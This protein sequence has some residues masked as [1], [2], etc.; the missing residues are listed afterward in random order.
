MKIIHCADLHLGSRLTSLPSGDVRNSKKNE[1]LN[2]FTQ[3]LN[4]AKK[5]EIKII[6]L[7]GDVF[8]SNRPSK[9]DKNYFYDA[10]RANSD[11]TFLYLRGNH[12]TEES[13]NETLDNLITFTTDWKTYDFDNITISGIELSETNKTSLY[14]TIN[15]D[16]D[17]INI[18]MMHGDVSSKG[19]DF[20]DYKKLSNKNIDYLALGHIHS[21]MENRI[22]SRGVYVYPGCLVGRGFDELGEKG[23]VVLDVSDKVNYSFIPV[24]SHQFLE[25]EID[26]SGAKNLY[27]AK[28]II[29]DKIKDISKSSLL[30][31]IL[32][33]SVDFDITSID[34]SIESFFQQNFF[35]LKVY[36]NVKENINISD[37]LNDFSLK[38]EFVRKVYNDK[39]LSND[40][41]NEIL[42]LGMKLLNGEDIE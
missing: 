36:T 19:K 35:F 40:E 12:D 14:S 2:S 13:L 5:N 25:K 18:V 8:D 41:R 15:L 31:I 29:N 3:M 26:I 28:E 9:K 30:K 39:E 4:Y 7:S 10:I 16:K 33:G 32:V 22:D 1:V 11:I 23:F 27:D 17:K 34:S 6:M 20:I 42:S 37:Y 38:G 24:E 21:Y